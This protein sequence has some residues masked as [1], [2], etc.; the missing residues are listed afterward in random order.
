MHYTA[1]RHQKYRYTATVGTQQSAMAFIYTRIGRC[2]CRRVMRGCARI[3]SDEK[4]VT[5][6]LRR[7]KTPLLLPRTHMASGIGMALCSFTGMLYGRRKCAV[8]SVMPAPIRLQQ[9]FG[10]VKCRYVASSSGNAKLMPRG[11]THEYEEGMLSFA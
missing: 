4:V 10:A 3:S 6:G 1:T 7:N 11:G 2:L 9:R 5:P 8:G